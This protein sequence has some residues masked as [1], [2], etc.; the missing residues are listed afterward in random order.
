MSAGPVFV[1]P[2]KGG[3]RAGAPVRAGSNDSAADGSLMT[4]WWRMFER[5]WL[6]PTAMPLRVRAAEAGWSPDE[7]DAYCDRCGGSVGE[8]EATEF[9]CAGCTGR[10]MRWERIVRLGVYEGELAEWIQEAKFTKWRAQGLAL[11]RW[12][13]ERVKEA[14]FLDA[15][16]AAG[17]KGM[18]VASPTSFRRRMAR[19]IDH[20]RVIAIGVGEELGVEVR[21]VLRKRHRP[22]QRSVSMSE[23]ARNVS[24]AISVKRVDL[25]GRLVLVVDD[26]MTS[27]ATLRASARALAGLGAGRK[28]A[29]VWAAVVGVAPGPDRRSEGALR[30]QNVDK[31]AVGE[32]FGGVRKRPT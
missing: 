27:G 30:E 28:P 5:Q 11:G 16:E 20:A 7:A 32:G 25:S 8:Y 18:V 22:S 14:G 12:L 2:P 23:R 3:E 10:R 9:G 29:G 31:L 6:A 24:G 15:A 4:T 13:G 21:G 17:L 26:V 19:G 1:W